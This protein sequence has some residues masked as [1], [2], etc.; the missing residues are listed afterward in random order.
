VGADIVSEAHEIN[1]PTA[2]SVAGAA[3]GKRTDW[4]TEIIGGRWQN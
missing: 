1:D 4:W 2:K 3:Q